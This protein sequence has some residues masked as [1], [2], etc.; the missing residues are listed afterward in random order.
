VGAPIK[1]IKNSEFA[2]FVLEQM[3]P[4]A[5]IHVRRMFGG[6]GIYQGAVMF[7]IVADGGLYFKADELTRNGFIERGLP[8]FSYESRGK[9]VVLQYYAAPP[10]VFDETETMQHWARQAIATALRAGRDKRPAG[11]TRGARRG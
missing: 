7:A 6:H 3:A 11:K 1:S 2:D 10:E 4:L 5:D 9:S 8:A